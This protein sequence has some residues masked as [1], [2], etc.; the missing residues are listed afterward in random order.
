VRFAPRRDASS[1]ALGMPLWRGGE[2][3][4]SSLP[5][6]EP[7]FCRI[8]GRVL[9]PDCGVAHRRT[10]P[11]TPTKLAPSRCRCSGLRSRCSGWRH[12]LVAA[13]A[14]R[15][16]EDDMGMGGGLS[17]AAMAARIKK[18]GTTEPTKEGARGQG[19]DAR[20]CPR[21]GARGKENKRGTA[22]LGPFVV[23]RE[24]RVHAS[25]CHTIVHF[26]GRYGG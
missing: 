16:G 2:D 13:S 9:P 4:R 17:S 1:V 20:D 3:L 25:S 6:L 14:A 21:E 10:G 18:T 24:R 12:T 7:P 8:K 11:N 23:A 22:F 26:I 15:P 19:G 5:G